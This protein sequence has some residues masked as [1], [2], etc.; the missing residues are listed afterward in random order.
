MVDTLSSIILGSIGT[1][2]ALANVC[3]AY[4]QF[5]RLRAREKYESH[6]SISDIERLRHTQELL[7]ADPSGVRY[8]T[9][10]NLAASA[11]KLI[12]LRSAENTGTMEAECA[13][14]DVGASGVVALYD[15]CTACSF[16]RESKLRIL[17]ISG[18]SEARNAM[19]PAH[20]ENEILATRESTLLSV[21]DV[22]RYIDRLPERDESADEVVFE[23]RSLN[24]RS[25][26]LPR[27]HTSDPA[28][29]TI[30]RRRER[31]G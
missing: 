16:C 13:C 6:L 17:G 30:G 9:N 4:L 7:V 25:T 22:D 23:L 29:C 14:G 3:I 19:D 28:G 2:I 10:H 27:S 5:Q 31:E 21:P 1:A 18:A 26:T 15:P 11:K 8:R 20:A 12:V 24:V